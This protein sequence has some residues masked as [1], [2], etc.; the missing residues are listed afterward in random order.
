MG[1]GAVYPTNDANAIGIVYEDVDVTLGAMPGS[2]VTAGTIYADRLP[3]ALA[4]AAK[5]ALAGLGFKI[6]T[7]APTITRPY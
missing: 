7:A 3:T 2:V 6:V 4:S 5:T 1:M